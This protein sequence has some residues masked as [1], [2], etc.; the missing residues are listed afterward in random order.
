MMGRNKGFYT[1]PKGMSPKVNVM[2]WLE[3]EFTYFE[4]A[5]QH[6]SHYTTRLHPKLNLIELM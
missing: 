5:V 3:I 1:F 4:A 2:V 6:L